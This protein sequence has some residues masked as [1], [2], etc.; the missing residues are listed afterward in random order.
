MN[1]FL[2]ALQEETKNEFPLYQAKFTQMCNDGRN[3]EEVYNI[4]FSFF[5][6]RSYC[7]N[8]DFKNADY[9]DFMYAINKGSFLSQKFNDENI[10]SIMHKCMVYQD[11]QC[12]IFKPTNFEESRVIGEP[13]CCFSNNKNYWVEHYDLENEAIYFVFEVM[14]TEPDNLLLLP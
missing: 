13:I 7:P 6:I 12:I 14:R 3:Q 4:L 2:L 11:E 8:F 10:L 5:S 1:Q 9:F